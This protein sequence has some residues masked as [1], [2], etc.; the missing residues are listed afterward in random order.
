MNKL[1]KYPDG[2]G[3]SGINVPKPIETGLVTN[4]ESELLLNP[5]NE[6]SLL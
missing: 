1:N 3:E 5:L 2:T 6:G 4:L